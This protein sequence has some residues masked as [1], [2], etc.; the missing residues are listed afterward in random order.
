[1]SR[2]SLHAR[3]RRD[4]FLCSAATTPLTLILHICNVDR[5]L[6]RSSPLRPC[7]RGCAVLTARSVYERRLYMTILLRDAMINAIGHIFE[8]PVA[9]VPAAFV[10]DV[11]RG[12]RIHRSCALQLTAVLVHLDRPFLPRLL[13]S[14]RQFSPLERKRFYVLRDQSRLRYSQSVANSWQN[15]FESESDSA[16]CF[17]GYSLLRERLDSA[18]DVYTSRIVTVTYKCTDDINAIT[19]RCVYAERK[20]YICLTLIKE[21]RRCIIILYVRYLYL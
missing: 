12:V 9:V 13:L 17:N 7:I 15:H 10:H 19:M 3:E 21:C 11:L 1:M 4:R 2:E 20:T 6:V 16:N 18:D 5:M 8:L 14:R